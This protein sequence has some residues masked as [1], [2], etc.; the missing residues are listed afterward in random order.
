MNKKII[1]S[2]YIIIIIFV[3]F[4]I[5]VVIEDKDSNLKIFSTG[6]NV[7][8][9]KS[10]LDNNFK[11]KRFLFYDKIN[12]KKYLILNYS[13]FSM[14]FT[15][16]KNKIQDQ[17]NK[18]E[19]YFFLKNQDDL[20]KD[21]N[22]YYSDTWMK[23]PLENA[24]SFFDKYFKN[25]VFKNKYFLFSKYYRSFH[26]KPNVFFINNSKDFVHEITHSIL[27]DNIKHENN[28]TWFEI[29]S[30]ANSLLFLKETNNI[31]YL[32][33][34]EL[35]EIGFYPQEYGKS[36]LDFVD[37][38]DYNAQK[39]FDFEKYIMNNYKK[40]NDNEFYKILE[41]YKGGINHEN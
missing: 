24:I 40:I 28:D 18:E 25:F 29:V 8:F 26:V 30:E 14:R 38:F 37:K 27:D 11:E 36:V 15:F 33:E 41:N 19:A 34:I 39:I 12:Y 22:N 16:S 32:N 4:P 31:K 5:N 2:I 3:L 9:Y 1:F 21:K 13:N 23:Y 10:D 20:F 17:F 35:K 7:V 6:I